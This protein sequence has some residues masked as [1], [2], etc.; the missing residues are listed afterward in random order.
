MSV[1]RHSNKTVGD[2]G[3]G[4][5]EL[6]GQL[7]IV[8]STVRRGQLLDNG[9]DHQTVSLNGE[10]KMLLHRLF[11]T[12]RQWETEKGDEDGLGLAH[13]FSIRDLDC[14]TDSD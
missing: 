2:A 13:S 5:F 8:V 12:G 1:S 7:C 11:E 10:M 3:A 4:L 9:R 6:F 14:P